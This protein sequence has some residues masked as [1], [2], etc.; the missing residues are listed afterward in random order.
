MEGTGGGEM[1]TYLLDE[2][3]YY[4]V[5]VGSRGSL[6]PVVVYADAVVAAAVAEYLLQE[7]RP[8]VHYYV[9]CHLAVAAVQRVSNF[10][11]E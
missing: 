11:P 4:V 9:L 10:H 5:A 7:V 2:Q 6:N 3:V 8:T 1:E